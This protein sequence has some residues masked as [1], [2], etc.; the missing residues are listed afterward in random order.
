[1]IKKL[2]MLLAL[3]IITNAAWAWSLTETNVANR[4][5][6]FKNDYDATVLVDNVRCTKTDG[7][8]SLHL[9]GYYTPYGKWEDI[10]KTYNGSAVRKTTQVVDNVVPA[11]MKFC[12]MVN[13]A[14]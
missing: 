4:S 13:K 14:N 12:A 8:D 1:M 3:G 2:T 7:Y 6:E 10:D 11:Y 9:S 5:F